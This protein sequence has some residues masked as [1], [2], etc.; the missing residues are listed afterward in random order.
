MS[1]NFEDH[2]RK[3][4]FLDQIPL[5]GNHLC[6]KYSFSTKHFYVGLKAWRM[7]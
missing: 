7:N 3:S 2:R 5:Q 1:L 6:R 4:G